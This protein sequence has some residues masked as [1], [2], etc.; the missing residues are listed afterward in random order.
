MSKGTGANMM[1]LQSKR[2]R[3]RA[4]IEAEEEARDLEQKQIE[5]KLSQVAAL[6]QKID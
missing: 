6:K 1:K 5:A 3:T 4:Q 2:R